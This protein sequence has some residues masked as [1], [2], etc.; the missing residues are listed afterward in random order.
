MSEEWTTFGS[1]DV[2]STEETVNLRLS[3]DTLGDE[4]VFQRDEW[5]EFVSDVKSGVLDKV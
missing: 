5:D 4:L 1:V 2:S 3:A